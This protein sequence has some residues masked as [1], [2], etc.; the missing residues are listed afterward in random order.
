MHTPHL[1]AQVADSLSPL[2]T[3]P[4]RRCPSGPQITHWRC[5]WESGWHSAPAH[6]GGFAFA[7][8]L[9]LLVAAVAVVV[10]VRAAARK[11]RDAR[12]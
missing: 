7:S 4:A 8:L 2:T 3:G 10:A 12:Q 5:A 9:L 11:L 1:A 6:G